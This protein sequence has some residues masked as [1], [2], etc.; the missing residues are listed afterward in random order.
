[1]L[2]TI[3]QSGLYGSRQNRVK[4]LRQSLTH[5]DFEMAAII[6]VVVVIII[7]YIINWFI[8]PVSSA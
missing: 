7:V 3:T 6:V 8:L 5:K 4:S 1:M 2:V